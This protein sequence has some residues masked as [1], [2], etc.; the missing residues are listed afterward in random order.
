MSR[1][2]AGQG[3]GSPLVQAGDQSAWVGAEKGRGRHTSILPAPQPC[4]Q[5]PPR[6]WCPVPTAW[7]GAPKSTPPAH[8]RLPHDRSLDTQLHLG[9]DA[10]GSGGPRP[11]ASSQ[12]ASSSCRPHPESELP[13]QAPH[14][15]FSPQTQSLNFQPGPKAKAHCFWG[16]ARPTAPFIRSRQDWRLPQPLPSGW[17]VCPGPSPG[18]AQRRRATRTHAV[19][20][21]LDSK[22]DLCQGPQPGANRPRQLTRVGRLVTVMKG[23]L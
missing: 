20:H 4:P 11:S 16:C 5:S 13:S 19:G 17:P 21:S 8:V 7:G 1:S 2:E 6:A 14:P 12:L 3:E 22:S 15:P 10:R 23:E 18:A 9:M